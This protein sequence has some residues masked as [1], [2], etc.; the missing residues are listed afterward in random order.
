MEEADNTQSLI[1]AS[2]PNNKQRKILYRIYTKL[3]YGILTVGHRE[4]IAKCVL[5][6][7]RDLFLAE[8]EEYMGYKEKLGNVG[9]CAFQSS[10]QVFVEHA[11]WRKRAC[12]VCI[13]ENRPRDIKTIFCDTHQVSL[14]SKSYPLEES[15]VKPYYC[16][17]TKL[18]CWQKYHNFFMARGLWMVKTDPNGEKSNVV[19]RSNE[20]YKLR[21]ND[22]E[23]LSLSR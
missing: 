3:K 8:N 5:D 7:I 1:D 4:P 11:I 10:E 14:C 6:E 12:K 20:L 9:T 18:T 19:C 16:P 17:Q 15:D 2:I 13:W 23:S 21:K 22:G